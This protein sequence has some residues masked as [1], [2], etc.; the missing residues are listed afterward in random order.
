MAIA[1]NKVPSESRP[2]A[3][4]A[5]F[6]DEAF[7]LH[8]LEDSFSAGHVTGNWGNSAVRKGTHDYY[9]EHG[10]ALTTWDH[11]S[12]VALGDA[13]MRP[14]DAQRTAIAVRDSLAQLLEAFAG[15]QVST[16][17]QAT[18][19]SPEGF[20]VCHEAHFPAATGNRADLETLAPVVAQTPVPA[21]G[22]GHGELPRFR[23]ELGPFL[24]LSSGLR[25]GVLTGGFGSTQTN[26]STIGGIEVA[27][28]AGV[29][30]EGILNESSDGLVFFEL[31]AREDKHASGVLTVP[32]RGT[33]TSRL[34]A[35]F[36]LIP[37]DLLIA[38][39]ILA[40]TSPGSLQKMAAQ[41]ANGGLIPWQSG[42]ATRIG[43]VQFVV[44]R[45][46]GVGL[47]RNGSD[48]PLIIPTPGVPPA[49]VTVITLRS[50]Q[51]DFPILEYRLFRTFSENQSSGLM[52]QPYVGFDKPIDSFIV[53]PT[54]ASNPRLHTIVIAGF[55]VV[56]DW[57]HYL[58]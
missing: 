7:A 45:E 42:I 54:G 6:A 47:Y 37:G 38:G 49:D 5:A 2:D 44:G 32:G 4:R 39:P 57:R 28:R 22:A 36:W 18:P 55:R 56:F 40:F 50:L 58:K 26:V 25:F 15:K 33:I 11:H 27:V 21:L 43:R 53:G 17:G 52:I 23:S 34:R 1:R 12:F 51:F 48:H 31:G 46:V 30:L 9:S 35:P 13:Y 19:A 29:G 10:V 3:V 20:D 8:F 14:E 16:T 41:A 24:G